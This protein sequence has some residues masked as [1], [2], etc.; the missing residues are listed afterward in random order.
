MNF[1]SQVIQGLETDLPQFLQE[2]A[3]DEADTTNNQF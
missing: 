3:L 2:R 1:H